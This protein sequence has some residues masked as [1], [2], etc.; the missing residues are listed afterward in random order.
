MA[1]PRSGHCRVNPSTNKCPLTHN[2]FR[3][4]DSPDLHVFELQEESTVVGG[5]MGR[6]TQL[7]SDPDPSCCEVTLL[8]NEPNMLPESIN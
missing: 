3:L 2:N 7:R 5:N 6:R 4:V 8:T 1:T